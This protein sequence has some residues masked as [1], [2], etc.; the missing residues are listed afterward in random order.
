MNIFY[1]NTLKIKKKRFVI[2]Q[3]LRETFL[4][5]QYCYIIHKQ[6]SWCINLLC[7]QYCFMVVRLGQHINIK[8]VEKF[9]SSKNATSDYI[10]NN[11]VLARIKSMKIQRIIEEYRL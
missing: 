9:L 1:G 10:T 3:E 11:E 2:D 6:K 8:Y 7:F 4:S 5:E